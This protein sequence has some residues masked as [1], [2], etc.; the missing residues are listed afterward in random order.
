MAANDQQL[1]KSSQT[2]APRSNLLFDQAVKVMQSSLLAG[3][4]TTGP[5]TATKKAD[6]ISMWQQ[7]CSANLSAKNPATQSHAPIH[8]F[9]PLPCASTEAKQAEETRAQTQR[10]GEPIQIAQPL[11]LVGSLVIVPVSRLGASRGLLL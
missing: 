8:P 7:I 11:A 10:P 4:P 3:E 6:A 9:Q 1:S 5:V 2:V